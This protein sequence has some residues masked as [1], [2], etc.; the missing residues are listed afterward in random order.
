MGKNKRG[1]QCLAGP[2]V[3]VTLTDVVL[4][5]AVVEGGDAAWL[6][7]LLRSFAPP[8]HSFAYVLLAP[9]DVYDHTLKWKVKL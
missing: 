3:G 7:R 9:A 8:D 6:W 1:G 5:I 4:R 2:A